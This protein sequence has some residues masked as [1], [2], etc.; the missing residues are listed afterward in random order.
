MPNTTQ[1]DSQLDFYWRTDAAAIA[2]VVQQMW[3]GRAAGGRRGAVRLSST[4]ASCRRA[5]GGCAAVGH[6]QEVLQGG[7]AGC[8]GAQAMLSSLPTLCR[9]RSRTTPDIVVLSS[10][11]WYLA[12][13]GAVYPAVNQ[14]VARLTAD[15]QQLETAVRQAAAE[16]GDALPLRCITCSPI[17]ACLCCLLGPPALPAGLLA[18]RL[19]SVPACLAVC[20]PPARPPACLPADATSCM[21]W[22]MTSRLALHSWPLRRRTMMRSGSGCRARSG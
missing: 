14:S 18:R 20:P 8:R 12:K 21:P 13:T 9:Q 4:G 2:T 3:V 19:P 10:G 22:R 15:L 1:S 11:S 7:A 17:S 16:V 6:G 5:A